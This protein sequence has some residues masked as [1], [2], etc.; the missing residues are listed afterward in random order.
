MVLHLKAPTH[1][2][3]YFFHK[4]TTPTRLERRIRVSISASATPTAA[5]AASSSMSLP[6]V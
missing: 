2:V 3:A 4:K 5:P 1:A 6:E